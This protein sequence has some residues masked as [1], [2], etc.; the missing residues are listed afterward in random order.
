[1]PGQLMQRSKYILF[2]TGRVTPRSVLPNELNL[3][4]QGAYNFA[5]LEQSLLLDSDRDTANGE[6]GRIRFR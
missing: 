5:E 1:M 2:S 4:A 6:H 3:V